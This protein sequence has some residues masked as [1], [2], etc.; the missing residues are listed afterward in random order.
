[1]SLMPTPRRFC[2]PSFLRPV[3]SA[4]R[5]FCAPSFLRPVV[6]APRRFCAPSFLRP[7]LA[8]AGLLLLV[9]AFPAS[10]QSPAGSGYSAPTYGGTGTYDPGGGP[11]TGPPVKH[12]STSSGVPGYGGSAPAGGSTTEY[13]KGDITTTFTWNGPAP[14]PQTVIVTQT[15]VAAWASAYSNPAVAGSCSNALNMPTVKTGPTPENNGPGAFEGYDETGVCG[16]DSSGSPI[17]YYT[18]IA[19]A[20]SLSLPTLSPM[21]SITGSATAGPLTAS[22]SYTAAVSPVII[23]LTGTL[24]DS[25]GRPV[26]DSKGNQQI[27]VGQGCTAGIVGLPSFP[28]GSGGSITYAWSVSGTT[29]QTWQSQT[30]EIGNDPFDEDASYYVSGPGRLDESSARWYWNDLLPANNGVPVTESVSCTAIVTPPV[31]Q[32]S[33]FTV[34]ASKPVS[35][36]RPIWTSTGTGGYMKVN[37]YSPGSPRYE[38]FAGPTA[39]QTA[40][41]L[42]GGMNFTATV[43]SP[44][45]TLFGTGS[46]ELVQLVT[47]DRTVSSVD[48]DYTYSEN[49]QSGLDTGYPY[50]WN[51]S[52]PSYQ[53]DDSPGMPLA[54]YLVS[55]ATMN[56]QFESFLMYFPPSST[57]CVPLAHFVWSTSGKAVLPNS[58]GTWAGYI[59][60]NGSDAAGT[61]TPSGNT[62]TFLPSNVFP[63]WT[64]INGNGTFGLTSPVG[65]G[66]FRRIKSKNGNRG[67]APKSAHWN[68]NL[69]P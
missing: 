22:V 45:I 11:P 38:L 51:A 37:L 47:P 28:A 21:A 31:G 14:V 7:A 42:R 55:L 65:G 15:C 53:T 26:L 20:A 62:A 25:S 24:K 10:A 69:Q 44:D 4:P 41:G 68:A 2:A 34:T 17:P 3:V 32:G 16:A 57:Q 56:D 60:Q 54:D 30:P 12:Y 63:E 23:T 43:A 35:V 59:A 40:N 18:A 64:Q 19:G 67:Y 52:V 13:A 49:G 5:R 61:V 9:P 39:A 29:F 27:L 6:S 58:T 66:T 1:M 46:L 50:G 36:F 33:A 8:L 48:N